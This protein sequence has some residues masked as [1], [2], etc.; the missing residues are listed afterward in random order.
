M[1]GKQPQQRSGVRKP[2][3]SIQ[4]SPKPSKDPAKYSL[5]P[6]QKIAHFPPNSQKFPQIFSSSKRYSQNPSKW[7]FSEVLSGFPQNF[8]KSLQKIPPK[9]SKISPNPQNPS[10]CEFSKILS[11]SSQNF[12]KSLQKILQFPQSPQ[13]HPKS[14]PKVPKI[15]FKTQDSQNSFRTFPKNSSKFPQIVAKPLKIPKI[16]SEPL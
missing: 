10:K 1:L 11:R 9:V 16:P 8:S 3:K 14:R 2:P 15:S 6:F 12:S 7:E 5:K 4:I 13:N